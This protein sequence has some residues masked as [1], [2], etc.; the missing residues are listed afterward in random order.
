MAARLVDL[1]VERP[2]VGAQRLQAH[3]RADLGVLHLSP[4]CV[5]GAHRPQAGAP[6][7][8]SNT[9]SNT[10]YCLKYQILSQIQNTV[11][12]TKHCLKYCPKCCPREDDTYRDG[13]TV[14]ESGA[15]CLADV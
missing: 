6:T 13:S 8:V 2:K 4:R 9:V 7:T 11:S 3:R 12:N 10:K 14:Q 1:L 15:A 5:C